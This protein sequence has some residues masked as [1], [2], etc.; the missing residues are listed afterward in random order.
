MLELLLLFNV[1][2]SDIDFSKGKDFKLSPRCRVDIS[3]PPDR[4]HVMLQCTMQQ[5]AVDAGKS[6]WQKRILRS[7]NQPWLNI[8]RNVLA[9]TVADRLQLPTHWTTISGQRDITHMLTQTDVPVTNCVNHQKVWG[10]TLMPNAM[11]RRY[12][13]T[14]IELKRTTLTHITRIRLW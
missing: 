1:I 11:L 3:A 7:T 9:L 5:L 8:Q 2:Q 6:L 13:T 4:R 10:S 14:N 12:R